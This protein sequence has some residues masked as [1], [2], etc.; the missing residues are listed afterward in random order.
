MNFSTNEECVFLAEGF[1][2][3][4]MLMT[5]YNPAYY[6]DLMSACGMQKAKDLFAFIYDVARDMP[7]KVERVAA[8]CERKGIR[9]RIMD[10][11]RFDA[12][13]KAFQQVYN[14][15]WKDNWG[16]LPLTDEELAFSAARLKPLVVPDI[17]SI[18]EKDGEPVGFLG[19]L[20]DFNYVLRH[21]GGRLTPLSLVKAL[22]YSR[23]I[24]DLRLLLLGIRED[25]RNRGVDAL[26]YREA[27]KGVRRGGYKRVEFS[28]ILEDNTAMLRIID[29]VGG[30]RYKSF[31]IYEKR[32]A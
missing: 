2:S 23:K 9:A 27:F 31:R 3:P 7:E 19:L 1:G 26:M 11:S 6:L 24:P 13:M 10:K 14:S 15:A 30:I 22:I 4:S 21:M 29:M 18:A 5:P 12:D 8:L 28:W 32:I 20:P 17:I 16:F 25:F